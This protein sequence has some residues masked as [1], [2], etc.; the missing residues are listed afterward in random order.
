M[1]TKS[2]LIF[3]VWVVDKKPERGSKRKTIRIGYLTE[4]GLVLS[5]T[6]A[7][8]NEMGTEKQSFNLVA[9][10]II[11][12]L[13]GSNKQVGS[14]A[15]LQVQAVS[16]REKDWSSNYR[17]SFQEACLCSSISGF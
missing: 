16:R 10:N 14:E 4:E 2:F 11:S 13:E 17:V 5:N 7:Y 1:D 12:I 3:K 15:K 8:L 9:L 6:A